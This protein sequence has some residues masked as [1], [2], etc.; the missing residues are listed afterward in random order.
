M[1]P[2][3][4]SALPPQLRRR[5]RQEGECW[6]WTGARSS[7]GY[8]I[9][10]TAGTWDSAH[11]I[12][13]R[14][15]VGPIPPGAVIHHECHTPPCMRP[16]HL[17]AVTRK[18]HA[19]EHGLSGIAVRHA[20]SETCIN[21]HAFDGH[22]G[23]SR[24]CSTCVRENKRRHADKEKSRDRFATEECAQGHSEWGWSKTGRRWCRACARERARGRRAA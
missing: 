5:F 10:Y 18:E 22:N 3:M 15:V 14:A 12:A 4:V 1:A 13:Y 21:G 6:L 11:R 7:A 23:H 17:R 9:V 19:A 24:T 16:D 20:A 2:A 8:G